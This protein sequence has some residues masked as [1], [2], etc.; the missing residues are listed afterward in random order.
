MKHSNHIKGTLSEHT[1]GGT[2]FIYNDK[3]DEFSEKA[4]PANKIQMKDIWE[5][6][7]WT[8]LFFDTITKNIYTGGFLNGERPAHVFLVIIPTIPYLLKL[9]KLTEKIKPST[10][11][12]QH[13]RNHKKGRR[14]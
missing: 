14:I 10:E 6:G 1:I 11:L 13:H 12:E 7:Q 9:N 3:R 4:D 2:L 8:N 5:T